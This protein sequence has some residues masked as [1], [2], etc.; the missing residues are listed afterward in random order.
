MAHKK[1]AGSTDN[2]RDSAPQYL[3]V[4]KFGGEVAK[5]GNI[6]VR[7]RGTK[8]HPGVNVYMSKDHTLHASVAGVVC[9]KRSREDRRIVYIIP[10]EGVLGAREAQ[11]L[12]AQERGLVE[13]KVRVP[14]PVVEKPVVAKKA[15]AAPKAEAVVKTVVETTKPQ[16][17]VLAPVVE[18]VAEPVVVAPVV[19][20]IAEPVVVAPVVEAIAEPVVVAPV[21][22]AIAE[23]VVVAPVV[24]AIA[25]P[26][27][28]APVVEVEAETIVVT[29]KAE[30]TTITTSTTTTT[31]QSSGITVIPKGTVT[32]T[33][34]KG[35]TGNITVISKG[36]TE[37]VK[38]TTEKVTV[39]SKGE[40]ETIVTSSTTSE[41]VATS[42]TEATTTSS[43]AAPKAAKADDLKKIEGIGPKIEELLH[44]AGIKTFVQLSETPAE[45]VK[46]ILE[47]AGPRYTMH[48]PATWAKQAALAAEGKWDELK[49]WQD[50]LDGGKE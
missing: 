18:A 27:V 31:T 9:F 33:S 13:H 24:E 12:K 10:S 8:F 4:K 26:V 3:G 32:V 17:V 2:G 16:P 29:P 28:V 48:N 35:G 36:E 50:E 15:A 22:E 23:P 43:A 34:S 47:A 40:T 14:K 7:Q 44:E 39:I 21:V 42:S 11:D 19:E 49:S 20:A 37:T 25:E 5:A 46:E 30:T 1:G 6:I 45:K 41:S 38:P